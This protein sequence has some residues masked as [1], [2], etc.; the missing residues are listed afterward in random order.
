MVC[1]CFGNDGF[2]LYNFFIVKTILNNFLFFQSQDYFHTF[3]FSLEEYVLVS[4]L[5]ADP[6][7]EDKARE[8]AAEIAVLSRKSLLWSHFF[9]PI[10]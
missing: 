2:K 3:S 1:L 10:C 7:L 6:G 9:P 5:E 4:V 8:I